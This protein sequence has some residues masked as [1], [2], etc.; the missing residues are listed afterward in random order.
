LNLPG[1]ILPVAIVVAGKTSHAAGEPLSS[2]PVT[3]W[4]GNDR[5]QG[6]WNQPFGPDPHTNQYGTD[7]YSN[8]ADQ[9]GSDPY[10]GGG[11]DQY[12]Q[13][14]NP[15]TQQ[16]PYPQ[17]QT[18]GFP[19]QGYGPPPP[20]PKRSKLPM[21][22]SLV[23]IVIIIGAVVAIVLVNRKDSQ[24]TADPQQKTSSSSEKTSPS[25]RDPSDRNPTSTPGG[26]GDDW[27]AVDNTADSGL[28][29]QVPPDWKASSTPRASGLGVDFTGNADYGQYDCE[30]AGYVRTF[31]ASG[32][33]Q[34]K[35]GEDLDLKST[36]DDFAKSFGATYYGDDAKVDVP[37]PTDIEI[38]GKKAMM[39]TA[40]VTPTVTKP[41][42][43]ATK[44]EVALVGILLETDGK[45]T[46]VAMLVVV[47]DLDG[48]PETPKPLEASVS[49]DILKTVK[50]GS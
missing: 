7:P 35:S 43:Q 8:P 4:Q 45:P 47:N 46:G 26:G 2:L 10:G 3:G 13:Q 33:V 36:M 29:Y 39:L 14:T 32:D 18:G 11:Y 48:G 30:G 24:Q 25:E 34:G 50:V 42:C 19:A 20:P 21:I 27:I 38:D 44:G 23:A 1:V 12:G 28:T 15:Y 5:G 37:L 31:A 6:D 49:Q 40:K 22:L 41:A 9:Y 17:Y 16:Q